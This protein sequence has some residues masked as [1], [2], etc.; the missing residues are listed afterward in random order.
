M[1]C[2]ERLTGHCLLSFRILSICRN[3]FFLYKFGVF[4]QFTLKVTISMPGVSLGYSSLCLVRKIFDSL[5]NS[6]TRSLDI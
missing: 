6:V 2:G 3:A 5:K 1:I 4:C